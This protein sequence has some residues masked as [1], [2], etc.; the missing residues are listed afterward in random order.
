MS[1][2]CVRTHSRKFLTSNSFSHKFPDWMSNPTWSWK[3]FIL[4]RAM[5]IDIISST[6]ENVRAAGTREVIRP[7][8]S[9]PYYSHCSI[10]PGT[11]RSQSKSKDYA[12]VEKINELILLYN[13]IYQNLVFW[14]K[15]CTTPNFQCCFSGFWQWVIFG[16]LAAPWLKR[17]LSRERHLSPGPVT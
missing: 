5:V 12:I 2:A 1:F 3:T 8:L 11:E 13:F 17:W 7:H 10:A 6:W 14:F 16:D 9:C 4:R 15:K